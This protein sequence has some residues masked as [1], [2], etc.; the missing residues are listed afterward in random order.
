MTEP[1]AAELMREA[2]LR[3]VEKHWDSALNGLIGR[4]T[5]D[6]RAL[7]VSQPVASGQ[8]AVHWRAVLD[9]DQRAQQLNHDLHVVGFRS[10]K[11]ADN[12]VASKLDFDGWRYS[13][14]PL[15][16]APQPPVEQQ[17]APEFHC[18]SHGDWNP[19]REA[20]CPHC[21]A[22]AREMLKQQ[23]AAA[24]AGLREFANW[25]INAC[26][27]GGG[28]D[29]GEIQ[30]KAVECGL[31]VEKTMPEP[32]GENCSCA[33][34]GADFP[35]ICYRKTVLLAATSPEPSRAEQ[36]AE[37]AAQELMWN[38]MTLAEYIAAGR[39]VEVPDQQ[40]ARN[41]P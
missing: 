16:A 25:A 3:A 34:N 35:A 38:G 36:P 29:G 27:E 19:M 32:C 13:I 23:R 4:I 33:Q 14:E 26:F 40:G 18:Q 24:Q 5:A 22:E 37:V 17:R 8:E 6:I 21:M 12:W 41:E 39:P 31:L 28:V 20:A 10:R 11:S 9:S 2:C 1:T 15:Y 30:D 7:P